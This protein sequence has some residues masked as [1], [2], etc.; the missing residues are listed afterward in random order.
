MR[1]MIT[2]AA[3][4][5]LAGACGLPQPGSAPYYAPLDAYI[6]SPD[7]D[8]RFH[9]SRPAYVAMFEIMPGSHTQ[10]IY[11]SRGQGRLDGYVYAGDR[12]FRGRGYW[13]RAE[14]QF[15]RRGA[16]GAVGSPRFLFLI[17]SDYPLDLDQFG[18]GGY[19]MIDAMG[20]RSYAA[21]SPYDAMERL[22]DLM[23][24]PM[25]DDDSWTADFYV[26]WPEVMDDRLAERQVLVRCNGYQ[27][28]VPLEYVNAVRRQ[29]CAPVT[30]EAPAEE[31]DSA[32][33]VRPGRRAPIPPAG[34]Q[35]RGGFVPTSRQLQEPQH[36]RP[37]TRP[38]EAG[39]ITVDD[40]DGDVEAGQP[41]RRGR[42][43]AP[44]T[45][46]TPANP[47]GPGTPATP[48]NPA[49]PGNEQPGARSGRNG[50]AAPAT[51]AIPANPNVPGTPATPASP[52]EPG[53][54]QPEAK[55]NQGGRSGRGAPATPAEPNGPGTP[56]RP[57]SPGDPDG[58]VA[59][60]GNQGNS[61]AKAGNAGN[62][63]GE[64]SQSAPSGE[65]NEG[66]ASRRRGAPS[67]ASGSSGASP[68]APTAAPSPTP[69]TRPVSRPAQPESSREPAR[70][71]AGGNQKKECDPCGMD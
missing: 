14:F 21:Y 66:G 20:H 63:G 29:L 46:A 1:R 64:G 19:R 25:L 2:T 31:Q 13:D 38:V 10:L 59:A 23:I 37:E 32:E 55:G 45:P 9:V 24:P 42:P 5:L 17:A 57:A 60:T 54:G 71:A 34:R 62:A 7:R 28:T 70:P 41:S 48:A 12:V 43:D 35:G 53:G 65:G 61:G 26:H 68:A 67:G 8:L 56:A 50:R 6:M 15:A 18:P 44:V 4:A 69:Q 39:R 22:V 47:N 52:A 3:L 16:R 11:P 33:I 27:V 40:A 49:N 51:P 36:R 58:G 30:D